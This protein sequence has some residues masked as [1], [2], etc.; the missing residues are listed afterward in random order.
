[1]TTASIETS[2][3]RPN[4]FSHLDSRQFLNL[5]FKWKKRT[6]GT[7]KRSVAQHLGLAESY[8]SMFL[9]GERSLSDDALEKLSQHIGLNRSETSYLQLLYQLTNEKDLNQQAKLVERLRRFTGYREVNPLE[10]VSAKYLSKWFH[11]AIRELSYKPD[12][13]L[14]AKWIKSELEF[15]VGSQEIES[16][17]DFLLENEFITLDM[18][19]NIQVKERVIQLRQQTLKPA[20]AEFHTQLLKIAIESIATV[21]STER[22]IT[23]HTQL[24]GESTAR[25]AMEI[26]K[27]AEA[28]IKSLIKNS[29]E[30]GTR[31][32]H[33]SFL[34]VPLTKKEGTK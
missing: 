22:N 6:D 10:A 25:Q 31:V 14:D 24:V 33:F 2:H 7:T 18:K 5:Y 21:P 19:G 15:Q 28:E 20:L 23:G 26:M 1:M 12:F 3:E 9:K 11:V 13:Q 17:I 30:E 4:V 29:K 27:Q 32:Y 34:S 8:L 16:A